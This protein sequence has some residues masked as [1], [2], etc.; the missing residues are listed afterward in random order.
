MRYIN[1]QQNWNPNK[2]KQWYYYYSVSF[3]RARRVFVIELIEFS[4]ER[5]HLLRR[6]PAHVNDFANSTIINDP[7]KG[8]GAFKTSRGINISC[9]PYTFPFCFFSFSVL[10]LF[11]FLSSFSIFV[12][13]FRTFC[14]RVWGVTC[15]FGLAACLQ[16]RC[17]K[18]PLVYEKFDPADSP[19]INRILIGFLS[20][21]FLQPL[22]SIFVDF[23]LFF[24]H[25]KQKN[26]IQNSNK[27]KQIKII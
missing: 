9:L 1:K 6:R 10:F 18:R 24:E 2:K 13:L 20:L 26:E 23:L 4:A 11:F 8:K 17:Q 22:C 21:Q 3:N 15:A 16:I 25:R 19:V 5:E 27:F 12:S 7:R 14:S